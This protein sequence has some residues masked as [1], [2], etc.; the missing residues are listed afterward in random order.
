MQA[1]GLRT[2]KAPFVTGVA[3]I[4]LRMNH[5][6]VLTFDNLT[7]LQ[8]AAAILLWGGDKDRDGMGRSPHPFPVH[9]WTN[10]GRAVLTFISFGVY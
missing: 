6:C 3:Q 4:A 8:Y 1:K 2:H 10:H 5:S 7:F 9:L